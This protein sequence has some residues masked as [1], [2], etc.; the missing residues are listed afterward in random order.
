MTISAKVSGYLES[1]LGAAACRAS[2][3]T[4]AFSEIVWGFFFFGRLN[5]VP[6]GDC[7]LRFLQQGGKGDIAG[8]TKTNF[9]PAQRP[10]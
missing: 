7:L 5:V 4:L 2:G 8:N 9:I 6:L 3:R 10:W 1:E